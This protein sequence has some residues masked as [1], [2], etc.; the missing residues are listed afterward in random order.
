[1]S[2]PFLL[3]H[4]HERNA[5]LKRYHRVNDHDI[6]WVRQ[7]PEEGHALNVDLDLLTEILTVSVPFGPEG[8]LYG[9]LEHF[10]L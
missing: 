1:M 3:G 2:S 8:E 7:Q 10:T 6:G 5:G 4:N 9:N